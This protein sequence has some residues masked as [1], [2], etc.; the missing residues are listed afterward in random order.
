VSYRVLYASIGLVNVNVEVDGVR[1]G[2]MDGP[3]G[4]AGRRKEERGVRISDIWMEARNRNPQH[5]QR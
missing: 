5:P 1:G 3:H 2:R 4:R